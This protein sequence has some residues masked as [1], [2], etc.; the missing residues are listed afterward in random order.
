MI[1]SLTHD[2]LGAQPD[3]TAEQEAGGG[4]GRRGQNCLRCG[5]LTWL[6]PGSLYYVSANFFLCSFAFIAY[7][8]IFERCCG[9]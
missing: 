3:A 4:T 9:F 2:G 7:L 8:M 5:G 6:L 1:Y